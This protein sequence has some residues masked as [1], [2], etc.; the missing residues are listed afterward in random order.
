MTQVLKQFILRNQ[1]KFL[2]VL[3]S[4][5]QFIQYLQKIGENI[6]PKK[7]ISEKG[8]K[9]FQ[10]DSQGYGNQYVHIAIQTLMYLGKKYAKNSKSEPTRFKKALLKLEGANVNLPK[11]MT[12]YPDAHGTKRNSNANK[13]E[14]ERRPSP[15]PVPKKEE[16]KDNEKKGGNNIASL[17]RFTKFK[18]DEYMANL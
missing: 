9:A 11:Q 8:L 15:P 14:P 17:V 12:Y 13:P 2:G 6:D 3:S 1:V 5:P 7:S 4:S 18:I 10:N 16:S